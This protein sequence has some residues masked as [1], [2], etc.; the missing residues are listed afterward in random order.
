[1]DW[2]SPGKDTKRNTKRNNWLIPVIYLRSSNY[3]L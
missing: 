2:Q 1:V 3:N